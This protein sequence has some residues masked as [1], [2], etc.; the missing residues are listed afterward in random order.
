MR[1]S[2]IKDKT[3][4]SAL[5]SPLFTQEREEPAARRQACHFPEVSLLSSQSLSVGPVR[6]GRCVTD[7][8][9]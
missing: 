2:E 6:A 9:G 3:V 1:D 5:T 4:G 8:F 7:C